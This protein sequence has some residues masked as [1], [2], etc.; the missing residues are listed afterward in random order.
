FV[1]ILRIYNPTPLPSSTFH[2]PPTDTVLDSSSSSSIT[3]SISDH[4][5]LPYSGLDPRERGRYQRP[6]RR[7]PTHGLSAD[8][9]S[10]SDECGGN[11]GMANT[12]RDRA[13]AAGAGATAA[14]RDGTDPLRSPARPP[15]PTASATSAA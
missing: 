3:T 13:A 2:R 12:H 5:P 4:G 10:A 15:P 7:R 11:V 14:R 8:G 9:D 6:G 1:T